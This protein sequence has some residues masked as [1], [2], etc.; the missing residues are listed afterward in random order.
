LTGPCAPPP[1]RSIRGH[2]EGSLYQRKWDG[3]WVAAVSSPDGSRRWATAKTKTAARAKLAVM[4][5]EL[6]AGL[7]PS[8]ALTLGDFLRRWLADVE[9]RVRTSTF[10]SYAQTCRGPRTPNGRGLIP[11]L[12]QRRLGRLSVRDVE[13]YLARLVAAGA[14]GHT[15]PRH[16]AVLSG[17]LSDAMRWSLVSS[18]VA[19]LA[20][21]PST[22]PAR[23]PRALTL[24]EARVLIEGTRHDRLHPLWL[25]ALHTGIREAE[26]LGLGWADLDLAAG[27]LTVRWQL[28][29]QG[30]SWRRVAPKTKAGLR[31][32]ALAPDVVAVLRQHQHRL[33]Q[34]RQPDGACAGLVFLT[35][36]G[37]P[38]YGWQVLHQLHAHEERLGL[39]RVPVHDLRHSAASLM[40]EAGLSLE[41]VKA[42]LGH[43]SIRVTS[44]TYSHRQESQRQNVGDAMQRALGAR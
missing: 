21:L 5:R 6:D 24:R 25:L 40:L 29:R 2:G 32:I 42:T 30:G 43:S 14:R 34:E 31:T 12:G 18:N 39:P 38:Y 8:P 9:G 41:D 37:Q 1:A 33:A 4:R 28:V 44:D 7:E 19:A 13:A 27:R 16:R 15:V 17:A 11:A 22:E 26:L 10:R 3:L 35:P 20:R 23:V 36:E